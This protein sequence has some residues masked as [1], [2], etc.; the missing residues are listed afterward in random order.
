MK[1]SPRVFIPQ[2]SPGKNVIPA[3]KFGELVTI[4]DAHKQV[5]LSPAP[6]T[7]AINHALR[8]FSD[9]D[10]LLLIGD[11]VLV[12]VC[13]SVAAKFN[14]GRMKL[15]KWDRQE[16]RYYVIQVAI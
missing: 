16:H 1:T 4:F 14:S 11:P 3:A 10:Y 2:E 5:M 12:G 7:N 6:A 9:D 13:C 8:N 15:L